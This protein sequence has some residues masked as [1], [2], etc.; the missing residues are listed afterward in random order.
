M[1]NERSGLRRV[2]LIWCGLAGAIT[3]PLVISA[4]S[5]LLA[6]RSPVY[7]AAG[8]AGVI[9]LALMLVQPL[10]LSGYLAPISP[11]RAR[12]LHRWIGALLALMVVLHVAGLWVTSPPD[13]VDA[14]LF[15]SP[16]PFSAWGVVAMWSVFAV[17]LLAALRRPLRMRP[18]TWRLVHLTLAVVIVGGTVVHAVLI[19]GTMGTVSKWA[20]CALVLSATINV[21]TGNRGR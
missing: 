20:L 19:E 11:L 3:L 14:L 9:G 4:A 12:V 13:V 5:P 18:R 16:T 17:A 6:W 1:G 15:R 21:I 8:F 2:A 7:I 10:L